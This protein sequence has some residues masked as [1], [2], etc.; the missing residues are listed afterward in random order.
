MELVIVVDESGEKG[1]SHR[2][3]TQ[4]RDFGLM[5]AYCLPAH[6]LE[7]VNSSLE[8]KFS[9]LFQRGVKP[10]LT[11]LSPQERERYRADALE[12]L[13]SHKVS[14]SYSAIYVN[15]FHDQMNKRRGKKNLHEA[16]F[17][18]L[19]IKIIALAYSKNT[20]VPIKLKVISDNLNSG[21][22]AKF[23]NE[24][25]SY[26]EFIKTGTMTFLHPVRNK[27]PSL[28][29]VD[30]LVAAIPKEFHTHWDVS[31]SISTEVSPLTFVADV[32]SHTTYKL[33]QENIAT[34]EVPPD[35]L[36]H[37]RLIDNHPLKEY[38]ICLSSE[39]LEFAE[40]SF[41]RYKSL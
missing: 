26:L 13:E 15:G 9:H 18:M 7:Y 29:R 1:S 35:K 21:E 4:A 10:H 5:A 27:E 40:D 28:R 24:L 3:E 31:F 22:I 16:L 23:K 38:A 11:D 41:Y 8:R 36:N 14:W 12:F 19:V 20:N 39:G 6:G 17:G 25:I 32:L 37:E 2:K 30:K 33:L 34:S